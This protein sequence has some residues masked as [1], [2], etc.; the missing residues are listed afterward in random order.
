VV[1]EIRAEWAPL[2]RDLENAAKWTPLR[3]EFLAAA[4]RGR[5]SLEQGFDIDN[6]E[7]IYTILDKLSA[8]LTSKTSNLGIFTTKL[9]NT[10]EKGKLTIEQAK[11][12]LT[13][14]KNNPSLSKEAREKAN[15]ISLDGLL[16]KES[17]TV[18]T[19][20][21]E[22]RS[23]LDDGPASAAANNFGRGY[24]SETSVGVTAGAGG[25]AGA[26]A[27]DT[28]VEVAG[29]GAT[30]LTAEQARAILEANRA[31]KTKSA[32]ELR[33]EKRRLAA[34][35]AEKRRHPKEMTALR[36]EV[37]GAGSTLVCTVSKT[38]DSDRV[39]TPTSGRKKGPSLSKAIRSLDNIYFI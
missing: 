11:D 17:K 4:T 18:K 39:S 10:I 2:L 7:E 33:L 38:V 1:E 36:E 16:I 6:H 23:A 29:A 27:G 31:A 30:K 19:T 34:E 32:E 35:A 8:E 28:G 25:G 37:R 12:L 3:K 26:G 22:A 13:L 15:K 24:A 21:A 5:L 14:L 20:M 9:I